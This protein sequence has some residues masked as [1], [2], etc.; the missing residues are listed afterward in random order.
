MGKTGL[1]KNWYW[2]TMLDKCKKGQIRFVTHDD[3]EAYFWIIR[4]LGLKK[5]GTI[6]ESGLNK[7]S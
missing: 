2:K 5:H 4:D 3:H 7:Q 6:Q 1:L